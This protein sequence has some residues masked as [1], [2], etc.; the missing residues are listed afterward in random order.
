MQPRSGL[1]AASPNLRPPWRDAICSRP[2][3]RSSH[4]QRSFSSP[5]STTSNP[6]PE[7]N[8]SPSSPRVST[9]PAIHKRS[10]VP[11]T[12]SA[13][14]PGAPAA[15]SA[16]SGPDCCAVV[17]YFHTAVHRLWLTRQALRR[18]AAVCDHRRARTKALLL[19]WRAQAGRSTHTDRTASGSN[20]PRSHVRAAHGRPASYRGRLQ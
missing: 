10:R 17:I 16:G 20:V 5:P 13:E 12:R 8:P 4:R 7:T 14:R 9:M 19:S 6:R 11:C 3:R 1:D 18:C 15:A 2:R